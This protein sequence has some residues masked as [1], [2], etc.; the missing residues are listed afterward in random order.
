M[1][2]MGGLILSPVPGATGFNMDDLTAVSP[3]PFVTGRLWV[4]EGRGVA[5]QTA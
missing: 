1:G 5:R 2:V 3:A 4:Q